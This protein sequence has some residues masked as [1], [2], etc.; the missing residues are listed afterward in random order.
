MMCTHSHYPSLISPP[1]SRSSLSACVR[2]RLSGGGCKRQSRGESGA[3]NNAMPAAIEPFCFSGGTQAQAHVHTQGTRGQPPP[4]V[5]PAREE[6]GIER[7]DGC[8]FSCRIPVRFASGSLCLPASA[9]CSHQLILTP[10]ENESLA[11]ES[12]DEGERKREIGSRKTSVHLEGRRAISQRGR[13]S[14]SRNRLS[15]TH[16][17][18]SPSLL[19]IESEHV[20]PSLILPSPQSPVYLLS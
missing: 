14:S 2:S 12:D 6:G 8:S 5:R 16:S 10:N 1:D 9:T 4:S 3:C 17:D 19:Q 7:I 11:R 15:D 20:N 18:T 13:S